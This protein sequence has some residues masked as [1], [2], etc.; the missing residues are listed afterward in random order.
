MEDGTDLGFH[1]AR[2]L[3][4]YMYNVLLVHRGYLPVHADTY[5]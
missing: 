2:I 3:L 5:S 1:C 4:V